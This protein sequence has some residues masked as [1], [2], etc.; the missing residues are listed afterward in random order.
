MA[1]A[2]QRAL[3][4]PSLLGSV[5]GDQENRLEGLVSL[6]GGGGVVEWEASTSPTNCNQHLRLSWPVPDVFSPPLPQPPL[7]IRQLLKH[8]PG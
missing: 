6:G 4:G 7:L 2:T 5:N 1:Q 3:S 8:L